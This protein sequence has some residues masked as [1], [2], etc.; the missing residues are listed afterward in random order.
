[1][2]SVGGYRLVRSLGSGARA[3]VWLGYGGSSGGTPA[4]AAVKVFRP[5][6]PI[7]SVDTEIEALGRASSRH[8]VHLDDLAT[9][10]NGLPCLILQRLSPRN[11]GRLLSGNRALEPGEAVTILA[12][13]ALAV[14]ELHRVGVVHGALRPSAVLFDDAGAPVIAGFG[15]ARLIGD[16]PEPPQAQSLT[17]AQLAAQPAVAEDLAQLTAICRHVLA[18]IPNGAAVTAWLDAADSADRTES[19]AADLADRLFG[20]GVPRAVGFEREIPTTQRALPQRFSGEVPAEPEIGPSPSA[21]GWMATLHL[22]DGLYD[23]LAG[24]LDN[25]PLRST[26]ERLRKALG[27]VRK[28]VWIVAG[29]VVACLVAVLALTPQGDGSAATP[30]GGRLSTPAPAPEHTIDPA[31]MGDDPVAAARALLALRAACIGDLSVL[32]LDSADQ[33]DS[34][35]MDADSHLIRTAQE[36]GVVGDLPDLTGGSVALVER[37]GDTALLTVDARGGTAPASLLLARGEAGWRI[38]DLV[39]AAEG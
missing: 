10:P 3:E 12:P 31:T 26:R 35:A 17:P 38:R 32:C 25:G 22:P 23:A 14:A 7:E 1:M 16:F 37:L 24:W 6:L 34:A 15:S 4:V 18:R 39:V 8:L 27:P 21:R 36:G 33:R 5:D 13:L 29:I 11:L 19:F 2:D 28:P 20:L 30:V 9:T